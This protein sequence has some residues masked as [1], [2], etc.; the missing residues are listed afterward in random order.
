M[1]GLAAYVLRLY[2]DRIGKGRLTAK[3]ELQ[4]SKPPRG[5]AIVTGEDAP[6]GGE[7]DVARTF[8]CPTKKGDIDIA[9]L[10]KAQKEKHLL[11]QAMAA[12]I[13]W[14]QPENGR[15][16]GKVSSAV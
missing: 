11:S 8:V 14:L 1:T 15:T 10:T 7:S 3:I 2:G 13:L 12:Y 6:P 16:V 9:K 4:E 5:I